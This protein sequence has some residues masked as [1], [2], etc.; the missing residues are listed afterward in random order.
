M[1]KL[2]YA[3]IC[4]LL[5]M[6]IKICGETIDIK[7]IN[8]KIELGDDWHVLTRDNLTNNKDLELF[9][10]DEKDM[11]KYFQ[12]NDAYIDSLYKDS[13]LEF[14]IFLD[15]I[16]GINFLTN[17]PDSYVKLFAKNSAE[18][19]SSKDYGIYNSGKYKFAKYKFY[20]KK[21]EVYYLTY[22]TVFNNKVYCFQLSD[23]EKLTDEQGALLENILD[24]LEV[25][26]LDEYKY[27]DEETQKAIDNGD[28]SYFLDEEEDDTTLKR[29]IISKIFNYVV[30]PCIVVLVPSLIAKVFDK[31]KKR[32]RKKK[33]ID[34]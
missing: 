13:L 18:D 22:V 20:D 19:V 23:Y 27:E 30:I 34:F 33:D 32:V 9:E 21:T 24:T 6:P 8:L 26:I 5:V 28:E 11:G 29:R 10:S 17:Y 25:K 4:L 15:K 2:L 7:D 3:V 31:K 16:E 1:K 12:D 14:T